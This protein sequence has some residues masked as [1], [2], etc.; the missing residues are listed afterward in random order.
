V[1]NMFWNSAVFNPS[2]AKLM[3]LLHINEFEISVPQSPTRYSPAGNGDVFYV[4]VHKNV[5]LSKVIF[6]DTL[7]SDHLSIDFHLLDHII[8]RNL[9]DPVDK[10][11][12]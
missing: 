7:D 10:F 2:G 5:R 9:S 8:T 12:D 4:V 6:S 3:N 1:L 11:I